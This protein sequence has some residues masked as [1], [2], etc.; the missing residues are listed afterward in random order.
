MALARDSNVLVRKVPG[1][2]LRTPNV[3]IRY[4]ALLYRVMINGRLAKSRQARSQRWP[5]D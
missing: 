3:L 2:F 5:K 4:V 1:D